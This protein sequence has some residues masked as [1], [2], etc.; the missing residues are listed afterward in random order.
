MST[1]TE[2]TEVANG[3]GVYQESLHSDSVSKGAAEN[4]LW[5]NGGKPS[6]GGSTPED[7]NGL[8][9]TDEYNNECVKLLANMETD[10][11]NDLDDDRR[12][13]YA[14]HEQ[15]LLNQEE[16]YRQRMEDKRKQEENKK[17]MKKKDNVNLR[18]LIM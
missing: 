17:K 8:S 7:G 6:D 15:I 5:W 14:E 1:T 9:F 2:R 16:N 4:D 12:R 10:E 11:P 18:K 3:K 13:R